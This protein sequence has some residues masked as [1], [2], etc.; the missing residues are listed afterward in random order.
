MATG[1]KD[2]GIISILLTLCLLFS[3]TFSLAQSH[4]SHLASKRAQAE[5][6]HTCC[7]PHQELQSHCSERLHN[8]DGQLCGSLI[9]L[10]TELYSLATSSLE[11]PQKKTIQAQILPEFRQRL[12]RPPIA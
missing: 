6:S 2:Q 3:S 4:E 8:C 10:P 7:G 12:L 1:V 9:T 5:H 11:Q